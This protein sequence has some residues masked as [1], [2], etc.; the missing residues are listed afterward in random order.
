MAGIAAV[1]LNLLRCPKSLRPTLLSTLRSLNLPS[2]PEGDGG[3]EIRH[4]RRGLNIGRAGTIAS[5]TR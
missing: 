3:M 2:S 5:A 4:S 1:R